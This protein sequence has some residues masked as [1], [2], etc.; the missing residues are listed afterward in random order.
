MLGYFNN[1]EATAAKWQNGWLHTGDAL[2]RDLEGNYYFVDRKSDYLRTRGNNVSSLE[3]EAEVRAHPDIAD[4]A[5]IAVPSD[6][7][8]ITGD[9]TR[10]AV[11]GD[12][13]IKI[14][15][16][17]SPDSTLGEAELLSF[18]IPRLPRYM[19]PRYVE[20][21]DDFPRTPTG[22]IQKSVLRQTALHAAGWDR[23]AAG[24]DVP[25]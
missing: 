22:K 15:A 20:F 18:L 7:A 1:A 21:V 14:V 6:L 2:R 13:D 17:R 4:C 5:C 25:K 9:T 10:A 3:V 12:D 16:S 19:V 24:I 11:M 23:V 8:R